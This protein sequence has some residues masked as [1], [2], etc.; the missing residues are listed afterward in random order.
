MGVK[1]LFWVLKKKIK[2]C[3]GGECLGA[4]AGAPGTLGYPTCAG[5]PRAPRAPETL[6]PHYLLERLEIYRSLWSSCGSWSFWNSWLPRI[7]EL[8]DSW[9]SWVPPTPVAP[10]EAGALGNPCV[11][12]FV[13][14]DEG[15]RGAPETPGTHGLPQ[16]ISW[17]SWET[18]S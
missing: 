13:C 8:Q 7:L 5:A 18:W 16:P 14:V 17:S 10:V 6:G 3:L 4:P 11:F 9:N 2:V 12:V 1:C 15:G